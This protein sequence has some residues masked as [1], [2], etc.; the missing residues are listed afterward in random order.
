M[1]ET[2]RLCILCIS[3][4]LFA[5]ADESWKSKQIADWNDD[6]AHQVL[7][8]SPWAKTVTPK[9]NK[10]ASGEPSGGRANIGGVGIPGMGGMGRRG[11]GMRNTPQTG[12]T[13]SSSTDSNAPPSLTVRWESAMPVQA[14]ELK[15][16]NLNAPSSDEDHYAIAVYGIPSRMLPADSSAV[17]NQLKDQAAIKRD[18]KKDLKPSSIEI[19]PR[20]DGSI[21]VYFFPRS[22]EITRQD[23]RIEFTAQIGRL[24]FSVPFT[25]DAMSYQGKLAL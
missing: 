6:D 18:G 2:V 23:K 15:A 20:D 1:P 3:L 12:S 21:A 14:A 7:S 25:V 19:I 22:K 16:R 9:V 13:T 4:L 10:A 24:E 5:A 8:D 17:D 11:G